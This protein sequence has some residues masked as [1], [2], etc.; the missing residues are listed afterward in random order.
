[1]NSVQEND[2]GWYMC[3]VRSIQSGL[4][5]VKFNSIIMIKPFPSQINT[6]PMVHRL[7]FKITLVSVKP[8]VTDLGTRYQIK[9]IFGN[10]QM[11]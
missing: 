10:M 5:S 7:V 8:I 2:R 3:Q 11:C 9:C 1:M 6:D 4:F